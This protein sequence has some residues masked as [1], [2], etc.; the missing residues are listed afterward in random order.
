MPEELF[1][2]ASGGAQK[3]DNG[4][5]LISTVGDGGTTLEVSND[6][7]IVWEAKYNLNLGLIHRAYRA[8]SLYP[9]EASV[10]AQGLTS[11]ADP[12]N[13]NIGIYVPFLD[14]IRVS[15]DIYN[16]SLIHI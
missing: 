14:S 16:L 12:Y 7:D 10:V 13:G 8:H 3:L 15:F 4:N 1:G 5:Y 2:H 11:I 9:V 6:M